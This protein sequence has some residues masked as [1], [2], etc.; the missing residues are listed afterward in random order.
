[1]TFQR[2]PIRCPYK[3]SNRKCVHKGSEI[4]QTKRKRLCGYGNQED[5]ELYCEWV[6]IVNACENV[7]N[8]VS[9]L[10]YDEGED[11]N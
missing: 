4:K 7:R 9:G 10:S 1:M 3:T 6:E 11:E 5:C 2:K 8:D